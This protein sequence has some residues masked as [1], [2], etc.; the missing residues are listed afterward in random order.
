[1]EGGW[2]G[3]YNFLLNRHDDADNSSN[4][5]DKCSKCVINPM[6]PDFLQHSQPQNAQWEE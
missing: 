3:P 4:E 1:M 5:N 2:E 6:Q